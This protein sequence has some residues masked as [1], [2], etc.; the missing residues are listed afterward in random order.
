MKKKARPELISP[1][2]EEEEFRM[3]RESFKDYL[4]IE[5][6]HWGES[7]YLDELAYLLGVSQCNSEDGYDIWWELDDVEYCKFIKI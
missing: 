4:V 7:D 6:Y 3:A 1:H 2:W 5:G